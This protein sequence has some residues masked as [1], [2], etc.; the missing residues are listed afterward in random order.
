MRPW[1]QRA[2]MRCIRTSSSVIAI[3]LAGIAV[4]VAQPKPPPLVGAT[5]LVKLT[6]PTGFVDDVVAADADRLVYVVADTASKAELH[7]VTMATKQEQIIDL[8]PVTLYPIALELVGQ[9]VFVV[10]KT[11]D[12]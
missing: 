4:A 12:G 3:S 7:V 5:E 2:S 10:G 1:N 9:R 8:A 6:T 11:E